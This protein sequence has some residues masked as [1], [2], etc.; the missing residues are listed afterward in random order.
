MEKNKNLSQKWHTL[1]EIYAADE[2]LTSSAAYI[3]NWLCHF[4]LPFSFFFWVK[5]SLKYPIG[6]SNKSLKTKNNNATKRLLYLL[7]FF[8]SKDLNIPQGM[9]TN[10]SGP[11]V[12]KH[13]HEE[14]PICVRFEN[15]YSAPRL[16]FK[17]EI[18][19]LQNFH[20]GHQKGKSLAKTLIRTRHKDENLG[21]GRKKIASVTALTTFGFRGVL[22]VWFCSHA[23]HSKNFS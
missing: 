21:W 10:P 11:A 12:K 22:H 23:L 16:N 7:F 13:E 2:L 17:P 1:W 4:C 9:L 15:D 3:S 8:R 14:K 18:C 19:P 20:N 6:H 5:A